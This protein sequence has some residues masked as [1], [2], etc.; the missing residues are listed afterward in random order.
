MGALV[1]SDC[2]GVCTWE[3]VVSNYHLTEVEMMTF[4]RKT[5]IFSHCKTI[6]RG[7]QHHYNHGFTSPENKK[8]VSKCEFQQRPLDKCQLITRVVAQKSGTGE[9]LTHSHGWRSTEQY[10][11]EKRVLHRGQEC[12]SLGCLKHKFCNP[13]QDQWSTGYARSLGTGPVNEELHSM[14]FKPLPAIESNDFSSVPHQ[15]GILALSKMQSSSKQFFKSMSSKFYGLPEDLAVPSNIWLFRWP[16]FKSE[17]FL[18]DPLIP[19]SWSPFV[20]PSPSLSR[21]V[22]AMSLPALC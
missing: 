3:G 18:P 13:G 7:F 10:T 11:F 17:H 20:G 12:G 4:W 5:S 21:H 8:N 6:E 22:H 19:S 14:T 15:K 1:K 2:T 9:V 16:N